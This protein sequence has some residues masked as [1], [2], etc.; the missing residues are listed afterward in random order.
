[1][2]FSNGEQRGY[3]DDYGTY[4]PEP[5]FPPRPHHPPRPS[6]SPPPTRPPSV[7]A[8]ADTELR[9]LR[10]AYRWLRRSMTLIVL[11]YFTVF[12][13]MAA[14]LPDLMSQ[15]VFGSVNLG[16][17][18]GL[19]LIPITLLTIIT[20]ELSAR[21]TVDPVSHRVRIADEEARESE[22]ERR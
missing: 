10:T 13:C 14:Y 8:H 3:F 22:E 12:L 6:H 11:G 7:P 9:R 2:A 16:V 19:L 15:S 1:M 5:A 4:R 17:F 21:A 18:L 20:Y